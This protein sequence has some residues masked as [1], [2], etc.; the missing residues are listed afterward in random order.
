LA[1][2]Y[3][4]GKQARNFR[5]ISGTIYRKRGRRRKGN[6]GKWYPGEVEA[7]KVPVCSFECQEALAKHE[8]WGKQVVERE[9]TT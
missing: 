3:R 2:C 7:V 8:V 5:V 6:D 4:C 1:R 9:E